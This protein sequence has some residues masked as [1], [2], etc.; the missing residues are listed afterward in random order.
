MTNPF[1]TK[2][3]NLVGIEGDQQQGFKCLYECAN[4][5]PG[6]RVGASLLI[7]LFWLLV[8]VPSFVP[9][10]EQRCAEAMQLI[11]AGATVYPDSVL[12]VWLHAYLCM[13][14]GD[15][16]KAIKLTE[17]T[18][19]LYLAANILPGKELPSRFEFELGLC[20]FSRFDWEE[21]TK[22]LEASATAAAQEE[23]PRRLTLLLLGAANC[24]RGSLAAAERQLQQAASLALKDRKSERWVARRAQR[25]LKR[26]WFQL[27]PLEIMYLTDLVEC[28]QTDWLQAALK[29][30]EG[31]A[32]VRPSSP[33]SVS[34]FFSSEDRI[35]SP[36]LS[37]RRRSRQTN[38]A[39]ASCSKES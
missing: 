28:M 16:G 31:L 3:A 4:F 6:T 25:F 5:R 27:F 10:K 30:L 29:H 35:L 24:M 8:Y 36:P 12:F 20:H 22:H 23:E 33:G 11:R 37:A 38:I 1:I 7:I 2:L 34:A 15:V 32:I 26:K 13:H 14:T 17:R 19:K 18:N 9:G 39:Y 21:A